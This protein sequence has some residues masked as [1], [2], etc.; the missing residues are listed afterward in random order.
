MSFVT[1]K[2]R[3]ARGRFYFFALLLLGASLVTFIDSQLRPALIA[4][5]EVRAH[6]LATQALTEAV[7]EAAGA[8]I[9]TTTLSRST[10]TKQVDLRGRGS[11]L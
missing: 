10:L 6:L 1:A 11:T 7:Y 5:A 9:P 8:S 2:K 3:K 4:M